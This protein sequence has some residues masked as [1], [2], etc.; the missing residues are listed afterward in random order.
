MKLTKQM[1]HAMITEE[2]K[3]GL[4]RNPTVSPER[5][6]QLRIKFAKKDPEDA[7]FTQ[8]WMS[9]GQDHINVE[10]MEEI[11]TPEEYELYAAGW[12]RGIRSEEKISSFEPLDSPAAPIG[13][14]RPDPGQRQ[15]FS[16]WN[17][18][19]RHLYNKGK[20]K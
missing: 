14:G 17:A 15:R 16:G 11:L 4:R 7:G 6:H 8:Y 2:V 10:D 18:P 3:E 9:L 1:L 13:G 19:K 12:E 20:K 5:L